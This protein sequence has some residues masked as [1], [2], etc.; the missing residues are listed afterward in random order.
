MTDQLPVPKPKIPVEIHE[1][2]QAIAEGQVKNAKMEWS[3]DGRVT[4]CADSAD[5]ASRFILEKQ[6]IGGVTSELKI[7]VPQPNDREERLRR[8]KVY[9]EKGMTQSDISRFTM[10]SQKTVSN[11]IKE[12]KRRGTWD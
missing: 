11:D 2:A 1:I 3:A 8:V 4:F 6:E 12:L 10:T 9:R 7:N 5:G